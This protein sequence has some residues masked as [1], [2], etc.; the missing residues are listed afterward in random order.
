MSK[1]LTNAER[2]RIAV[3]EAGH[4]IAALKNGMHVSEALIHEHAN[5]NEAAGHTATEQL[6]RRL[7]MYDRTARAYT[8]EAADRA[9]ADRNAVID[10]CGYLAESLLLGGY[11]RHSAEVDRAEANHYLAAAYREVDDALVARLLRRA[12]NLLVRYTPELIAI[13]AELF[14]RGQ[15]TEAEIRNAMRSDFKSPTL[16]AFMSSLRADRRRMNRRS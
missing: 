13:A 10:Y 11:Y 3:H 2:R 15:M 1:P 7:F 9:Y 5:E 14:R 4:A 16:T 12:T 6:R 8:G